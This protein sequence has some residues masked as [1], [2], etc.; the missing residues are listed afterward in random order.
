MYCG[1]DV[2]ARGHSLLI[3]ATLFKCRPTCPTAP[4]HI[5]STYF[6]RAR[7]SA[8]SAYT[9]HL[10]QHTQHTYML[11]Q[12]TQ[13]TY[14]LYQHTQHTYMLCQHTQHTGLQCTQ[15][16]T[17]KIP[18]PLLPYHLHTRPKPARSIHTCACPSAQLTSVTTA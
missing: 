7:L 18:Q 9:T 11:C 8:I 10:C 3:V 5:P 13:H 2:G 6:T 14:M 1:G 16:Y 15:T 4:L 17:L 12:H